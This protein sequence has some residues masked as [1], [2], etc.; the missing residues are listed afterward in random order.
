MR[1]SIEP[2]FDC[3]QLHRSKAGLPAITTTGAGRV[4]YVFHCKR[5]GFIWTD[6]DD[7]FTHML[8]CR[9]PSKPCMCDPVDDGT[10]NLKRHVLACQHADCPESTAMAAFLHG[11]TYN[12]ARFRYLIACW[13]VHHHRPY[14][15]VDDQE[16]SDSPTE[17]LDVHVTIPSR[18]T[19]SRD[20]VDIHA[21][22]M[23]HVKT[24][25]QGHP[26]TLHVGV[27]GWTSPTMFSFLGVT[28]HGIF[29]GKMRHILLDF[30]R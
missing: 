6:I 18:Q 16:L 1:L 2:F 7:R 13:G 30:V 23:A 3:L 10:L 12:V 4:A 26:G 15:I 29:D 20:V 8:L 24:M 11:S 28:I 25:L 27:D 22:S 21:M 17:M 9:F 19:V 5:Y 14:A